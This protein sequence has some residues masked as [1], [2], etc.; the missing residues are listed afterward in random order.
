[1]AN[2]ISDETRDRRAPGPGYS[3]LGAAKESGLPEK[4]IRR[5]IELGEIR[6]IE[7]GGVKR[8]PPSEVQRLCE[9]YA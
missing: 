6:V 1:M 7:F 5:A 3:I 4:R 2:R 8:I 9:L